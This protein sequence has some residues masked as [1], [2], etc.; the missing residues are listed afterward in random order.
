MW[1]IVWYR[2]CALVLLALLQLVFPISLQ[3]ADLRF[4]V[5]IDSDAKVQGRC[6]VFVIHE[7][8]TKL[9]RRDPIE[10]PFWDDPQPLFGV[11]AI[12]ADKQGVLIDD[13]ADSFP[14]PPSRLPAGRYR[15]QARLDL[16]RMNSDWKRE[17]GNRWSEIVTFE[18]TDAGTAQVIEMPLSNVVSDEKP[19]TTPGVEWFEVKSELLSRFRGTPVFLQAGIVLPTNYQPGRQYAAIYEVPGFGDDHTSAASRRRPATGPSAELASHTFRIVLNPEGP[20]G[21][22]LF[23][24]SENNGPCGEALIREL[25]PAIEAKY[26]LIPKPTARMLRGHSSGGWTTLWLAMQYPDAFGAAWS[27][28]PD[29]V[30]FRRFQKVDI[31]SQAS[32]Y[33]DD[34]GRDLPSLR[35]KDTVKMTIRQEARGEDILGPDNTSAQQWDSWFAVFGPRNPSGNPAAL[36]DPISGAI[37]KSMAQAYRKFDLNELLKQDPNRYL[38]RFRNHI[39]LVCGTEDSFYLNEAVALLD[40]EVQRLGRDKNDLG[41]IKLV[42][43][44][45]GTVMGSEAMRNFPSEMLA[46]LRSHGHVP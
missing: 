15:A 25:I 9:A 40:Q 30:D 19:K 22:T 17:P 11:N 5:T 46:H 34:A 45:H 24:D 27:S 14:Y 42:P 7:K 21:H 3:S 10:G 13:R 8:A 38:P 16:H 41:Y 37:D 26:P 2:F 1:L 33:V 36:F 39:R 18:V 32:F 44:D 43:G 35:S 28:A 4:R 20:N 23:A 29:P 6:V 12:F 31:Y